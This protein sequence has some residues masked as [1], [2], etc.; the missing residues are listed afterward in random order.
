MKVYTKRVRLD[1]HHE[2]IVVLQDRT[3]TSTYI[4]SFPAQNISQ[5]TIKL[6]VDLNKEEFENCVL[7]AAFYFT[8]LR[9]QH[10]RRVH[11]IFV[12]ILVAIIARTTNTPINYIVDNIEKETQLAHKEP[13]KVAMRKKDF[14]T[15]V[16]TYNKKIQELESKE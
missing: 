3:L 8:K 10:S 6:K 11:S 16:Y 5:Y 14:I 13:R 15:T 2:F 1:S 4:S 7:D 9:K 12:R